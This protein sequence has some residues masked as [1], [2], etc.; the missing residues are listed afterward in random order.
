M[1]LL[2]PSIKIVT[3]FGVVIGGHFIMGVETTSET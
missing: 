1:V 2:Y 3:S